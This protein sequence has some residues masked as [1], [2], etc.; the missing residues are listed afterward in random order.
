MRLLKLHK[1]KPLGRHLRRSKY[2]VDRNKLLAINPLLGRFASQQRIL[3]EIN[4]NFIRNSYRESIGVG[5][6][7]GRRASMDIDG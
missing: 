6:D 5:C 4:K 1:M 2:D 7:G 3:L